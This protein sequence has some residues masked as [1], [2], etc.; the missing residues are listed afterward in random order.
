MDKLIYFIMAAVIV[1]WLFFSDDD[2]D[3][4]DK[5]ASGTGG[6]GGPNPIEEVQPLEAEEPDFAIRTERGEDGGLTVE[7]T[8]GETTTDLGAELS[9]LKESVRQLS[10]V[11][12]NAPLSFVS[13]GRFGN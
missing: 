12:P 7:V 6:G 13:L 1:N 8:V 9:E 4:E 10:R 11:P 2:E 5:V 3:M